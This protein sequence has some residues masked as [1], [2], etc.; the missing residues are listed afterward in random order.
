M[1]NGLLDKAMVYRYHIDCIQLYYY[2]GEYAYY[3]Q[4]LFA[5]PPTI[6]N[7]IKRLK[8]HSVELAY[9]SVNQ[10]IMNRFHLQA[11]YVLRLT[12]MVGSTRF[13]TSEIRRGLRLGQIKIIYHHRLSKLSLETL[14]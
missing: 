3:V 10:R 2:H 5:S 1:A 11:K 8:I 7:E 6:L 12:N 13:V 4:P 9:L 14:H